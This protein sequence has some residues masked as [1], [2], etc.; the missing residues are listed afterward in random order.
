M[1]HTSALIPGWQLQLEVNPAALLPCSSC[2]RLRL[3]PLHLQPAGQLHCSLH[4][5][6]ACLLPCVAHCC[7]RC[8]CCDDCCTNCSPRSLDAGILSALTGS[9]AGC[10]G[11]SS[12]PA[13]AASTLCASRRARGSCDCSSPLSPSVA[14]AAVVSRVFSE[15]VARATLVRWPCSSFKQPCVGSSSM[16]LCSC[17]SLRLW[18]YN[19]SSC[20]CSAACCSCERSTCAVHSMSTWSAISTPLTLRESKLCYLPLSL[21]DL[22]LR[23]QQSLLLLAESLA[24]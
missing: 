11:R 2:L 20:C 9:T 1:L 5:S 14:V 13:L 6:P 3:H 4:V 12:K 24:A 7:C 22:E 19:C 18:W 16:A 23:L 8:C 21:C 10:C 15:S 17:S